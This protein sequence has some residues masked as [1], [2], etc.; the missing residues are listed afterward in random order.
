MY[1][2]AGLPVQIGS[3]THCM[4]S[5]PGA[6]TLSH[7]YLP[8][9]LFEGLTE[10]ISVT[11]LVP[12]TPQEWGSY[13]LHF[14]DDKN[15]ASLSP[16]LGALPECRLCSRHTGLEAGVTQKLSSESVPGAQSCTTRDQ[17]CWGQTLPR[18]RGA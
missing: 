2:A 10:F 18:A 8:V 16:S 13:D 11:H 12:G 3:V 1:S 17:H 9:G 5:P 14:T 7:Q 6:S 15:E 4:S